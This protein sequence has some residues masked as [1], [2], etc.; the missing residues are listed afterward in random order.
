[1]TNTPAKVTPIKPPTTDPMDGTT[2]RTTHSLVL[3]PPQQPNARPITRQCTAH[4]KAGP[5]CK[6]SAIPGGQVCKMHGGGAP[7]V[8]RKA[9]LRL[10]ELID[11]AVATLAR[12][13]TTAP[14]SADRQRAANSILDRA[15]VSRRDSPESELAKALLIERLLELKTGGR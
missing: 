15:G 6:R 4:T 8:K 10:L 14:L 1:M 12:E 9:A 5:R 7:Q 13:M 3:Q 2:P 11:P